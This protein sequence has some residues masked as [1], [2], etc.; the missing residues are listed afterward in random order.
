[1]KSNEERIKELEDRLQYTESYLKL[2]SRYF[3]F[4]GNNNVL[5]RFSPPGDMPS[6]E[7]P[8]AL[9]RGRREGN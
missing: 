7:V 4:E 5:T 9:R 6:Q 2:V 1:M 8:S 3:A